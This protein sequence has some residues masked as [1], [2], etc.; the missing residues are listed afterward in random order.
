MDLDGKDRVQRL[1]M[2]P[3]VYVHGNDSLRQVA[4]TLVEESIGAALVRGPHGASGIVSERDL[5]RAISDGA[6]PDRTRAADV[7]SEEMVMVEP[8]DDV[9]AAAHRMLDN[10]VRHLPVI[11]D[12]VT[13]GMVSARDALR[14]LVEAREAAGA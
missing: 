11:Q 14:A 9:L 5:V 10:E 7:M 6:D 13:Y 12:D 3:A 2:R 4:T 1:A 8:G